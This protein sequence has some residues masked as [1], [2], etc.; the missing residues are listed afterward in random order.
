MLSQLKTRRAVLAL[1]TALTVL[2]FGFGIWTFHGNKAVA[3]EAPKVISDP[4]DPMKDPSQ[5]IIT[6]K[7][8]LDI[9]IGDEVVGRIVLG[10]FGKD[11][12]KT[13]KNFEVLASTGMVD[14]KGIGFKNSVFHR[15]IPGFMAQGGDF[16]KGNGTGGESIYGRNFEDEGFLFHHKTGVISMAN[17]GK[18]TNGSQFFIT[19]VDTKWLDGHHVV[20]GRILEGMDVLKKMEA[21]GSR[22]GKT[23]VAIRIKDCGLL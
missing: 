14:K 13:V 15:I 6:S 10:L 3:G 20:F 2:L 7:V 19:L 22:S 17:A 23:D 11:L 5:G 16:T 12:P 1:G 9:Q 21:H 4:D 18:N 8:F